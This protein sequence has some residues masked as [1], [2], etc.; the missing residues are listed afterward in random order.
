M[1]N[2]FEWHQKI[3]LEERVVQLSC[4]CNVI[5]AALSRVNSMSVTKLLILAFMLKGRMNSQVN[6]LDGRTR[7]NTFS[8][9]ACESIGR[10]QQLRDELPYFAE[11]LQILIDNE[12]VRLVREGEVELKMHDIRK[13]QFGSFEEKLIQ[14]CAQLEDKY[15]L[16]EVLNNV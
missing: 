16:M 8:K 15:V 6:V 2:K 12:Y 10:F 5:Q 1:N 11:A 7:K 3:A 14:E 4:Y 9:A 13:C